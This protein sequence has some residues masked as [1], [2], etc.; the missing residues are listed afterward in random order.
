[1]GPPAAGLQRGMRA[2]QRVA[3]PFAVLRHVTSVFFGDGKSSC[4]A[5]LTACT[6]AATACYFNSRPFAGLALG[7]LAPIAAFAMFFINMINKTLLHMGASGAELRTM[8]WSEYCAS[9]YGFFTW[10]GAREIIWATRFRLKGS[11]LMA[12]QSAP[13]AMVYPLVDSGSGPVSLR[14]LMEAA[15]LPLV[16]NFGSCS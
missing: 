13:D 9:L 2:S 10:N 4:A 14:S 7:V 15:S 6:V 16:L 11:P 3:I 8:T 5:A 12:G 1:M